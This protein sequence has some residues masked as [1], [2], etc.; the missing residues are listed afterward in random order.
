MNAARRSGAVKVVKSSAAVVR[1]SSVDV[2]S[3]V[4]TEG[5]E[6]VVEED[7]CADAVDVVVVLELVWETLEEDVIFVDCSV[8]VAPVACWRSLP[9]SA[10]RVGPS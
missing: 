3:V 7:F 5:P 4:L 8:G 6:V 9:C 10:M 1:N 2:I